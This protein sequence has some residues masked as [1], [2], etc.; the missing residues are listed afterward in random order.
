MSEVI[1]LAVL[2]KEAG[3][4]TKEMPGPFGE[5]MYDQTWEK[6]YL[7]S[8]I[9]LL[10]SKIQ[11]GP[12]AMTGHTYP[13][14]F[15]AL[16]YALGLEERFEFTVPSG[17]QRLIPLKHGRDPVANVVFRV[18]E[19]EDKVFVYFDTDPDKPE[20][21]IFPKPGEEQ[22]PT[23]MEQFVPQEHSFEVQDIPKIVVPELPKGRHVYFYG[24]GIFPAHLVVAHEL[25]KDQLSLSV[26]CHN[27]DYACVFCKDGT[28]EVGDLFPLRDI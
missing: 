20:N 21:K 7:P 14:V 28:M 27:E 26:S 11:P 10:Q 22:G 1:D 17:R 15:L 8:V 3:I 2:G 18:L 16:V 24:D 25:G 13:W 4:P 23:N 9:R 19:E 5:V 12:V 6:Q